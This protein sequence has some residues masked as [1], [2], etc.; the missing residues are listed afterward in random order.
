[1]SPRER[2]VWNMDVARLEESVKWDVDWLRNQ[3]IFDQRT[4][5]SGWVYEVETG[6]LREVETGNLEEPERREIAKE[7]ERLK[8]EKQARGG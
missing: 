2:H 7:L 6:R 3:A 5:V 1:M 8:G 4:E